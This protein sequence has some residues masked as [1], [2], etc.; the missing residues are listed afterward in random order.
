MSKCITSNTFVADFPTYQCGEGAKL[1]IHCRDKD[2]VVDLHELAV[3]EG[4]L[5]E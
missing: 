5:K 2:V 4:L 3:E 1:T